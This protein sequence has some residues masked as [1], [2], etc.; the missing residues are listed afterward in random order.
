MKIEEACNLWLF[1]DFDKYAISRQALLSQFLRIWLDKEYRNEKLTNISDCTKALKFFNKWINSIEKKGKVRGENWSTKGFRYFVIRNKP[2]KNVETILSNIYP[3]GYIGY[4]SAIKHYELAPINSNSIYFVTVDRINWKRLCLK[5]INRNF[6][7]LKEN[8]NLFKD[9]FGNIGE[10]D[11]I[12]TYPLEEEIGK[13]HIAVINQKNLWTDEE[14]DSLRVIALPY[15]YIDMLRNPKYCGGLGQVLQIFNSLEAIEL[16][17]I[18]EILEKKSKSTDMDRARFGFIF[19]KIFQIKNDIFL[20]W[21]KEQKFKRGGSRKL[22]S[23]LPFDSTYDE[24]WNI[25]VNYDFAKPY[26]SNTKL[27]EL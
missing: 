20:N 6:P 26:A 9:I 4:M 8:K 2:R 11:L 1:E 13:Y 7:E 14:W 23:Y 17:E 18:I 21:K 27:S 10:N 12:P 25:S 19:D 15:L 3:I 22:V 24:D 5:K 16:A